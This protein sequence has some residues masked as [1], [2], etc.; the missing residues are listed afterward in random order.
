MTESGIVSIGAALIVLPTLLAII[1]LVL[2]LC[3]LFFLDKIRDSR[4]AQI[5]RFFLK[6]YEQE[7]RMSS[8]VQR[9]FLLAIAGLGLVALP[10]ISFLKGPALVFENSWYIILGTLAYIVVVHVFCRLNRNPGPFRATFLATVDGLRVFFTL[11]GFNAVIFFVIKTLVRGA[12]GADLAGFLAFPVIIPMFFI[13][14]VI[15][16]IALV[17]FWKTMSVELR[18]AHAMN[19]VVYFLT[20]LCTVVVPSIAISILLFPIP[21]HQ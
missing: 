14:P 13:I 6:P 3:G 1:L 16:L 15:A 11:I 12:N 21:L 4:V 19:P 8:A 20:M 5:L 7:N 17:M 10:T 2:L 18:S 9:D